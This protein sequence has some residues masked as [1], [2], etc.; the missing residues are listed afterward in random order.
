MSTILDALRQVEESIRNEAA[1]KAADGLAGVPD[2]ST[3]RN[4][5]TAPVKSA[6]PGE[7]GGATQF[8]S[9]L[10]DMLKRIQ[11]QVHTVMDEGRAEARSADAELAQAVA[12][13]RND[14]VRLKEAVQREFQKRDA[15]R[16]AGNAAMSAMQSQSD[17]LQKVLA[18]NTGTNAKLVQ[19]IA[20]LKNDFMRL[21]EALQGE[22]RKRDAE[23]DGANATLAAVQSQTESLKRLFAEAGGTNAELARAMAALQTDLMQQ[24]E[25]V[26][27]Q[28]EK[29]DAE[30]GAEQG[31]LAAIQSD[32]DSLKAFLA[33]TKATHA[34]LAQAVAALKDD[35]LRQAEAA[36]Q[37]LR[38]R[39]TEIAAVAAVQSL[40]AETRVAH[41][42]L[43]QAVTALKNDFARQN[44]AAP[45]EVQTRDTGSA[46]MAAEQP[47]NDSLKALL[48]EARES[49]AELARTLTVLQ[50]DFASLKESVQKEFQIRDAE[51]EA[52]AA[53]LAAV[54][55]Q[56]NAMREFSAGREES[57]P[58]PAGDGPVAGDAEAGKSLRQ[59]K[60][61]VAVPAAGEETK[62]A[63]GV[64]K[65][66]ALK[67][68]SAARKAY[69]KGDFSEALQLLDTINEAFPGNASVLYNRAQCLIGLGRNDEARRLC[70]HLAN[71]L[72]HAPAE[73]LKKQIKG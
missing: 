12:A 59:K 23:R 45:A 56:V 60:R 66:E 71:E 51:R 1:Q 19:A 35:F 30:R 52:G 18:E 11:E 16:D 14:S 28:F 10:L 49:N 6:V 15:E 29:R 58:M 42:E 54:Q 7:S 65:D 38:Q 20:S 17:S 5:P 41:A 13:L 57:E 3:V 39:E 2:P 25:T 40:L 31:S 37:G 33:D 73:E 43:A 9:G 26:R 47:Q 8:Y 32:N 34:S 70:D 62:P 64:D 48:E 22:A 50:G 68:H 27:K 69:T 24:A 61:Q 67:L 46:A 72:N 44:E 21:N 53:A 36:Q 55:S 4:D 63:G